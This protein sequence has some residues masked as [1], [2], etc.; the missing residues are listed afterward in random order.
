MVVH[1]R[2]GDMTPNDRTALVTTVLETLSRD[3]RTNLVQEQLVSMPTGERADMLG[4]V[5]GL[6]TKEQRQVWLRIVNQK[7]F[8]SHQGL[9]GLKM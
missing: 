3:E 5:F 6:M 1:T 2:A 8:Q 9:E 4:A 7:C